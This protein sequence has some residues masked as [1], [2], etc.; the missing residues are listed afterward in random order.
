M[1]TIIHAR[2][3]TLVYTRAVFNDPRANC[4]LFPLGSELA[5]ARYDPRN[6]IAN[7]A[8]L[9]YVP[10]GALFLSYA[11]PRDHNNVRFLLYTRTEFVQQYVTII[12]ILLYSFALTI[13]YNRLRSKVMVSC[14][15]NFKAGL[16]HSF[17]FIVSPKYKILWRLTSRRKSRM[18]AILPYET[19]QPSAREIEKNF[20][21]PPVTPRCTQYTV[22]SRRFPENVTSVRDSR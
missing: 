20:V 18:H 4:S 2:T 5:I 3:H 7:N 10:Q 16:S 15:R 14:C 11:A 13:V 19:C 21:L 6:S 17:L 9:F 1:F 22:Y 12:Y 8:A